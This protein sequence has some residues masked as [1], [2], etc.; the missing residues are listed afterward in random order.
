M[1]NR[2][3]I[4]S[5]NEKAEDED[6]KRERERPGKQKACNDCANAVV[7]KHNF[8][9]DSMN[10]NFI[11]DFKLLLFRLDAK[12]QSDVSSRLVSLRFAALL[13]VVFCM[14]FTIA[15]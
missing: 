15:R 4:S 2:K 1:R 8:N 12:T 11:F 13:C 7:L 5:S 14:R 10:G 3:E 9:Q 6:R